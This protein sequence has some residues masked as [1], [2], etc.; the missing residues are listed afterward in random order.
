MKL[1]GTAI[2]DEQILKIIDKIAEKKD[3]NQHEIVFM[4]ILP[5]EGSVHIQ[6]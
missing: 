6:V 3:T 5:T 2:A 1:G 4:Q